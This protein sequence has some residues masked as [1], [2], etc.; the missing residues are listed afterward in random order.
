[1]RSV[2][3]R[4]LL[5][6]FLLASCSSVDLNAKMPVFDPGVDPESWAQ[7]PA[8]E[9]YFGQHN[10]VETLPAFEIMVTDVTTAQ[11]ADFP[12]RG[13]RQAG[14]ESD[15]RL[16]SWRCLSRR[17]ARGAHRSGRLDLHPIR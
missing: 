4:V 14:W 11:Y 3:V 10:K 1:M 8:G 6:S 17:K 12:G 9:F 7:I 2:I 5:L 16:L 15:R 13:L